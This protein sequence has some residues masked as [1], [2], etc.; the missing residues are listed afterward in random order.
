MRI[1]VTGATGNLGTSVLG[2]LGN[3]P[4]VTEIIGIARRKT[5]LQLPKVTWRQANVATSDLDPLF[6]GIDAVAHLA[7][8]IRPSHRQD[9]LHSVNVDGSKRVFEAALRQKVKTIVHLSSVGVY[10]PGPKQPTDEDHGRDGIPTSTYS[11]HKAAVERII[12]EL[13]SQNLDVRFVRLRPG[14]IFKRESAEH[15]RRLFFG[16][17]YP[18][19][20]LRR[21]PLPVM[22]HVAGLVINAVHTGDVARAVGL[23]I[24]SDVRG[25]FNLAA[26]PPLDT[27]TMARIGG[28]LS[29]PLPAPALR[30]LATM[31]WQAHLQPTEPGWIDMALQTP[32]LDCTRARN[33]LAW[34]PRVSAEAAFAELVEGLKDGAHFATPPLQSAKRVPLRT[35]IES[36]IELLKQRFRT[37]S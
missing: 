18:I 20:I 32:L 23:A 2:E 9:I 21:R 31:S 19:A 3:N 35:G 14:L 15:I 11:M 28:G 1:L 33:E 30:G 12:D 24:D 10:S 13:E 34:E 25:A 27:K 7:W 16:S 6:E 37:T 17:L 4:Q 29:A 8:Q 26:E 22:P 36:G 5:D